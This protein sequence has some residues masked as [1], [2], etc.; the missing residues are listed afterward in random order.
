MAVASNGENMQH[1]RWCYSM[2][3]EEFARAY[4]WGHDPNRKVTRSVLHE[5][6]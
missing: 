6:E 5:S 3:G 1:S 2:A 4:S